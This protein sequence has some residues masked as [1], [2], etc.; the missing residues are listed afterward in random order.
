MGVREEVLQML[1]N[2]MNPREIASERGVTLATILGYLDQLVGRGQLRR[3][4]ILFSVPAEVRQP[5]L[6]KVSDGRSQSIS[7]VMGRLER[8]GLVVDEDDI[9]IVQ[10]YSDAAHALGE[11]YEDIRTIEVGLH[12][13]IRIALEEDFGS[14]EAGWWRQGIPRDI[15]V[16]CQQRREEEETD[17]AP[18]PYCYTDLI[19]LRAIL[20]K[21]WPILSRHLPNQ[22][23]GDKKMLLSDLMRLNQIRRMVMHPVRGGV[24][25]EYDFE[26]LRSLKH[27]LGFK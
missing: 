14:E 13:L 26:F 16:K 11:I 17:P 19:D 25:S 4:D 24:P 10:K 23:T 6:D 22:A 8:S 3:S 5:I 1:R 9:L 15:R 27:T 12:N 21:Q 2:G 20:D 18:E 7:A